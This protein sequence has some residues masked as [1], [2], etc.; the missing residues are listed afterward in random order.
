MAKEIDGEEDGIK[1]TK[2]TLIQYLICLNKVKNIKENLLK[3]PLGKNTNG[4]E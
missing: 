4:T 3:Q 2:I 1:F